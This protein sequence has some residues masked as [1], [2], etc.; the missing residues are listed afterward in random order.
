MEPTSGQEL[1]RVVKVVGKMTKRVYP[2][3]AIE[4]C[5]TRT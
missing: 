1:E 2:R 3:S 5:C 4:M